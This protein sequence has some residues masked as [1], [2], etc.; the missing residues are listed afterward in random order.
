MTTEELRETARRLLERDCAAQGIE[1]VVTD[2]V[3]LAEV[4]VLLRPIPTRGQRPEVIAVNRPPDGR[5]RGPPGTRPPPDHRDQRTPIVDDQASRFVD[6]LWGDGLGWACL[7]TLDGGQWQEHFYRWPARRRP[8]R[9]RPEGRRHG[10]CLC[11][12]ALRP[13]RRR[14]KATAIPGTWAWADLDVVPEETVD[15]LALLGAMTVA[16]RSP[17]SFHAYLPLAS[18]AEDADALEHLN[19]RLGRHLGADAKHYGS[20]VLRLPG[21]FN[22]KAPSL[23]QP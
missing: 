14:R 18:A 6:A 23:P 7:A 2:P 22:R 19:R 9:P 15:R 10:R 13:E 11:G 16:S 8:P 4:V 17:R 3:M 12:P 21:T 5:G 20:A 1:P